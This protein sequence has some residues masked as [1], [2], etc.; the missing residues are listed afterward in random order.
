MHQELGRTG[1][2]AGW[3]PQQRLPIVTGTIIRIS[4]EYLPGGRRPHQDIWLFHSG[5]PG[6]EPDLDLL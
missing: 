6:V 5:P 1:H 4:V 3:P 2:W